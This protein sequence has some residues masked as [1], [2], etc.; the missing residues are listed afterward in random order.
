MA[1]LM[2]KAVVVPNRTAEIASSHP[3]L[4]TT[5]PERPQVQ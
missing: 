4:A 3:L 5:L 1:V 2:E